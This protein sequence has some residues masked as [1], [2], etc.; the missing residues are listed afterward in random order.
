MWGWLGLPEQAS[1]HASRMDNFIG[2]VHI[3]IIAGFMFWFTWFLIAIVKHRK[4]KNP[5]ADY[6][7]I[8]G[9]WPYIPVVI[10]VFFDFALLFGLSIPFWHDEINA[11]PLEN[12]DVIELRVIAQR[13]RWNIHYPGAD[14]I[15]GRTDISLMDEQTNLIGLDNNDPASK[16]D[17]VSLAHMHLPVNKQVLIHL[18]TTD[19]IHSMNLPEFRIKHDAIPGM[20]IPIYFTPTMTSE[21]FKKVTGDEER[22]FEIACAQL[23][24]NSHYFMRGFITVETEEEFDAWLAKELEQKQLYAEDDDWFKDDF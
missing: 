10:M 17:I 8:K 6:S 7:G 23:C 14:G 24:G 4:T 13:F 22:G 16:D 11:V 2:L 15:F 3:V 21:E 9:K 5:D 20:R 12:E 18:G 19:V 1:A